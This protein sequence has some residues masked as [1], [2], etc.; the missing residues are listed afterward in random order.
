[1]QRLH[2]QCVVMLSQDSFYR[3]LTPVEL[4]NVAE[5]NFDHPDA[6]DKPE[7]AACLQKLK[8]GQPVDVPEY[9]FERHQR[10]KNSRRVEPADVVIIE[11]ILVL[12]MEEI[13]SLCNM[14]IFVDTGEPL[15]QAAFSPTL[16]H[17]V[18]HSTFKFL[19]VYSKLMFYTQT[20]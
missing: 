18:C 8:A 20:L 2:D 3:A 12:H 1:M 10:S 15:L 7:I 19:R 6:F 5:Y 17:C 9:D 4:S 11:G 13:R 14:S 16:I